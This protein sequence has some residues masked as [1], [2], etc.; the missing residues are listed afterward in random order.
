VILALFAA[1]ETT[2]DRSAERQPADPVVDTGADPT[3]HGDVAPIMA[4]SC[5]GCHYAGGIGP[6][7]LEDYANAAPMASAIAAA[8]EAGRMPP[9][10]ATSTD[11]CTPK[12]P[13]KDDL[14]LSD[15]EKA[16]IADW[17][18]AGAPEGDVSMAADLPE[19]VS[20]VLEGANQTLTPRLPFTASGSADE[21]ICMTMDP[22]LDHDRWLTGVQVNPGNDAVVHH[23]LI[24]SDD[25]AAS[26]ELA[27]EDGQYECFG[28]AGVDSGG[29]LGAWAPGAL[30]SESPE[31]SGMRVPAGA[32]IVMQVHYHP[33][34]EVAEPDLTSIDLRWTDDEPEMNA[35]LALV[36]NA[37]AED[38]GLLPGPNDDNGVEFRIPAGASGHTEEMAFTV[39]DRDA[40]YTIFLAGTHMHYVGTD[41]AIWLE[42][43]KPED[44]EDE[45][46]CLVQTPAWDFNWQR[47]YEYDADLSALPHLRGGDTLRMRC[48]YDNT[49]AN[50]GVAQS[51]DDAGLTEPADVYLGES[52]LDE[53][54]LGVFGILY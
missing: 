31:N 41:M 46:E 26:E 12:H 15:E 4:R 25:S 39:R 29:L 27:G 9:W 3:W 30:P 49:L 47:G 7:S 52:T 17:A 32:R 2:D 33:A 5:V 35:I 18:A 24:F 16:R 23:V 48:T 43:K 11:E 34:G 44:G 45:T 22:G 20:L 53:M 36:G 19:P 40:D 37:G 13:W 6:F 8:V 42:R 51:L 28:G 1:C 21:F 14:R 10:G 54:C 50:P 38:E